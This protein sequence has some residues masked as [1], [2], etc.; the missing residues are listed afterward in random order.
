ME[1]SFGLEL[2]VGEIVYKGSLLNI[3]VFLINSSILH[4]L[5]GMDEM[6]VLSHLNGISPLIN[7]LLVLIFRVNVVENRELWSDKVGEVT[8]LKVSKIKGNKILMMPDES[9]QPGVVFPTTH[10]GDVAD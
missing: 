6:I 10:S 8:E 2:R 5:L 4:L 7:E 1:V 9:S 3:L